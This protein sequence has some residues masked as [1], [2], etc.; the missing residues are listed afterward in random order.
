MEIFLRAAPSSEYV[1]DN[2]WQY[3]ILVLLTGGG[4]V[5]LKQLVNAYKVWQEVRSTRVSQ[6]VK[7]RDTAVGR[8]I[9]LLQ[10]QIDEQ[11][12]DYTERLKEK[13]EY[14]AH[15]LER[16]TSYSNELIERLELAVERLEE[17]GEE[18]RD[19]LLRYRGLYGNLEDI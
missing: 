3:V 5:A 7:D 8:V 18:M 19:R 6:G 4:T 1:A 9:E 14:Y 17:E 12:K 10:T 13:D 16:R 15:E 11:S 2:F